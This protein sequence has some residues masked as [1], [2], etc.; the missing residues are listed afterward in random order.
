MKKII[1]LFLVTC[2]LFAGNVYAFSDV[3]SDDELGIAVKALKEYGVIN[4]YEDGSFRPDNFITRAEFCKMVNVLFNFTDVGINDFSD[5]SYD[6][7]YYVQVLIANEYEYING[8][9]DNTFRGNDKITREQASAIITRITPL[10]KIDDTVVITDSVSSWVKEDVQMIANHKLLKTDADVKFRAKE[11]M[12]RGE[13][14]MLVSHFIPEAKT[15]A[16]EEGYQGTN[17][18]IAIENAVV[19]ANLQAAV[20]DI[21][22]VKFNSNEEE[23]ISLVLKGLNGTIDAGLSGQLI[24]KH[25]VVNHFWEEIVKVRNVT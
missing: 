25:Y 17:A 10:L 14:A 15:D 24:N 22:S 6:D 21:K 12:T 4:G 11:Y 7:W 20:R 2:T 3:K 5:V 18:E 9:E 1:T 8:F 13:L 16:W 23:M 19:L